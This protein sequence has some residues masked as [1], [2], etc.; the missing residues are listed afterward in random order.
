MSFTDYLF[1]PL[2]IIAAVIYYILPKK[3]RWF[4]LLLVSMA[5]YCSWNWKVLPYLLAAVLFAWAGSNWIEKQYQKLKN[6][7]EAEPDMAAEQKKEL[8]LHTKKKCKRIL[9]INTA[10]LLAMLIFCKAGK[11]ILETLDLTDMMTV[12]V[13]LGISYY[14]MS[15]IGYMADVYWKKE[16]AEKNILKLLLF[17][18]YF[19]KILEGPISK[20]RLLAAQL[21]E[22]RD[23]DYQ[24]FCFGLQRMI[25][26][27]FKKLVIADR[28]SLFITPVL[29]D[30]RHSS[31]S[32]LLLAFLFGA[33]QLY[34]DFSGCMDIALG[35]SETLG[36][37]LE[38]NFKRPFF[39]ETAA[40]FWRRWHITLGVWFK[41]YIYMPLVIS[42]RLIKLAGKAK[43]R[44]GK[45]AGKIVTTVIPL[46][47]VWLLTG[48][49]HGTGWNYVAWGLYWGTLIALSTIF[50]PEL[51]KLC[52]KLK[53]NV[54][55]SY[56]HCFRKIR[57]FLLF[58]VSRVITMPG[59]LKATGEIIDR[60]VHVFCPWELLDGTFYKLGIDRPNFNVLVL[61]LVLLWY[62]SSRQEKG[63]H[64]RERIAAMPIVLR[65]IV[66]F[67]AIFGVMI[68]G[69]YGIGYN[70][71]SFVYMNY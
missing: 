47:V 18:G 19:P 9:L 71:S 51:K 2:F 16:K 25:W 56:Y 8:Q 7:L 22:G 65:W 6:Q 34:C 42:P 61:T 62:V 49:W 31:G 15:L 44:F 58:V 40:E 24:T 66:Y 14:T 60:I 27:Y 3:T 11:L 70:A 26:G 28:L 48:I 69:T 68:F 20:H 45:R 5:F 54:Q 12:V 53:I 37:T 63:E 30:Y 10:F 4:F 38:E 32:M 64:M 13:P 17:A 67:A 29:A 59:N 1:L 52:E 35:A 36:I 50:E 33:F 46:S 23:F 55:G 57:T 21:N 39:S 43:K 41:D